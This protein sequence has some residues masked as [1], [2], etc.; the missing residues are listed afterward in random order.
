M[1]AEWW[2]TIDRPLLLAIGVLAAAGWILSLGASGATGQYDLFSYTSRQTVF[3]TGAGLVFF[4]VSALQVK[5][6]NRLAMLT[7]VGALLLLVLVLV[8]GFQINGSRRWLSLMGFSIQPSEIIKPA[9]IMVSAYLLSRRET[10]PG[11]PWEAIAITALGLVC[12]LLILQPDAGQTLLLCMAFGVC[13]FVAG[14]SWRWAGGLL[15]GG[16]MLI[17]LLYIALPHF[18]NRISQLFA[19]SS[20]DA[21]QVDLALRAI[22]RGSFWGVGPGEGR[23]KDVLPEAN[24]D[25]IYSVAAEEFGLLVSLCLIGLFL[26]ITLRGMLLAARLEDSFSRAA[27]TGLFALFGFQAA[28]NIL[29]NV[30]FAPPTGMTLP[31]VSHGG[32]SAFGMAL[33][34]GFALGLLRQRTRTVYQPGQLHP[35][36]I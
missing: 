34:L 33:T 36:G 27:C 24:T 1:F 6:I 25:F 11:L 23:I 14:L 18:R 26:F 22:S 30:D 13:I 21:T 17:G 31:L 10:A 12:V 8:Y 7:Y 3:L 16:I 5:W 9:L 2:R 15:A 35:K 29:V 4:M 32:S 20:N 19:P 28:V